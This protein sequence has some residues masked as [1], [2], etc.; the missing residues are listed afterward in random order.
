MRAVLAALGDEL[1]RVWVA[2][3][4]RGLPRPD[5]VKYPADTG[6]PHWTALALAV[7]LETVQANF[8]KYGLLD[9]RVV[10]LPG[11]FEDTLAK[12]PIERISMLRCDCDMYSSTTQVLQSLYARLEVGGYVIVDDYGNVEGCRAA[13]DDFRRDNGI[14]EPAERIGP[15][16]AWR[17]ES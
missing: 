16:I 2:D 12:A 6:D 3:S 5:I 10:F 13:V 4:F 17:R 7:S 11:W 15:S 14:L 9:E 8:E 1:R